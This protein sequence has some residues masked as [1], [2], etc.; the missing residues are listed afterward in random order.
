MVI[1]GLAFGMY[2]AGLSSKVG[3]LSLPFLQLSEDGSYEEGLTHPSALQV[4]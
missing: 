2:A 3:P 4:T 1:L